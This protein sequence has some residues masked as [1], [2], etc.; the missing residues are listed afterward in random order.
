VNRRA[1]AAALALAVALGVGMPAFATDEP[2]PH[3]HHHAPDGAAAV[4]RSTGGYTVPDV[5]L[6]R[7]DGRS[8]SAHE[9]LDRGPV[10]VGFIFTTCTAICPITSAT[11]H[12]VQQKLAPGETLEI[13]SIS[14]DPEQDTPARLRDYARKFHAAP[15]WHHYT[16]AL[17]ASVALQRAFDAYRGDKMEHTASAFLR[18]APGQ[19]WV[20]IDGFASADQLLAEYRALTHDGAVATR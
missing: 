8:V 11:F 6:V 5:T 14:I 12:Q 20:R 19:P 2:D 9:A 1:E 4:R 16:G 18:A 15:G 3:A 10:L 17:A 7:E 13:A